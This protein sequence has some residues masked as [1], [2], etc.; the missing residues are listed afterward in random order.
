MKGNVTAYRRK[1]VR[2][3][4][5]PDM[6]DR[7]GKLTFTAE[8]EYEATLF[9]L[10]YRVMWH[11][12]VNPGVTRLDLYRFLRKQVPKFDEPEELR[13]LAESDYPKK[14]KPAKRKG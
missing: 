5:Q 3:R 14:P 10:L 13:K 6:H 11:S 9:A 1:G 4:D 8:D 12:S 2:H 7:A